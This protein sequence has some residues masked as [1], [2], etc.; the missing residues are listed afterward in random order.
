MN[1]YKLNIST[2]PPPDPELELFPHP[3][4]ALPTS[5]L[6]VSQK[7][8]TLVTSDTIGQFFQVRIVYKWNNTVCVLLCQLLSFNNMFMRSI[9]SAVC[10]RCV[11]SFFA[12]NI[13][14]CIAYIV[15]H[16]LFI[17]FIPSF[18]PIFSTLLPPSKYNYLYAFKQI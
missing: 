16:N 4:I 6:L 5:M 11:Y 15:C 10:S 8:T 7:I 12:V 3:E 1:S 13:F 14:Y 2:Y 9:H 17:H 18:H